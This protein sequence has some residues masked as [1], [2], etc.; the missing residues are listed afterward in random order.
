M[1]TGRRTGRGHLPQRRQTHPR[2]PSCLLSQTPG[3]VTHPLS[4]INHSHTQ[5]I[6]R[7]TAL[8]QTPWRQ[9]VHRH[10][11]QQFAVGG[12]HGFVLV[13]GLGRGVRHPQPLAGR[14]QPAPRLPG[15]LC[16]RRW[17]QREVRALPCHLP[18]QRANL[19][20][21]RP[22]DQ[23]RDNDRRPFRTMLPPTVLT[24]R[25][26]GLQQITILVAYLGSMRRG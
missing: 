13:G 20:Q 1:V 3:T 12:H 25:K 5:L 11:V 15:A 7:L 18:P 14:V 24:R 26:V 10:S 4:A 16:P 23:R 21:A 6:H 19:G 2:R 17:R 22:G 8:W 9:T